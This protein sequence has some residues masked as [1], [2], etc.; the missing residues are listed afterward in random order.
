MRGV[1]LDKIYSADCRAMREVDDNSVQ[2]I[3]TSPPYNVGKEYAQHRDAMELREYLAFLKQV[4][5]ECTRV[6]CR[7]GRLAVN[8]ANTGRKPYVPLSA[9]ISQQLFD[10]GLL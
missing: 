3:V 2:L 10:L 7:G 5:Q 4:W 8:I 6:L 1:E 9:Y